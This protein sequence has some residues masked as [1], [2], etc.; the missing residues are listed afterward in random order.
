MS[1]AIIPITLETIVADW[2]K[3]VSTLSS[4]HNGF[5]CIPKGI[6]NISKEQTLPRS[7]SGTSFSLITSEKVLHKQ[8]KKIKK[9]KIKIK[10]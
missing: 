2:N 7:F 8:N 3:V 4:D 9:N 10:K 1:K 5:T 6:K